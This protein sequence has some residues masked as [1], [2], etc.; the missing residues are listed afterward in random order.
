MKRIL[1]LI[2]L[3]II[4]LVVV[5]FVCDRKVKNAAEGKVFSTA[6]EVP[7]NKVA[8]LLGTGK[9]LSNG[10]E[11]PYYTY[12]IDAAYELIKNGKVKYIVISGDNGTKA[13][14]EPIQMRGDLVKRGIDST[15]IF[16]DYA[17]FRTFDSVVR[18]RDIF[19]QTS[20]TVISQQFHNER[21]IYIAEHEGINAV[22]YNAKDVSG[23]NGFKVQ[24]REKLARVKVFIDRFIGAKPKFSGDKIDLPA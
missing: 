5:I 10:A 1:K 15:I 23:A 11:N 6:S 2:L 4:V 18:L 20:V 13:Y 9:F 3:L 21:A 14:N 22:G 24:F 8:L 7:Y 17:G 19:G 16:L 12:R